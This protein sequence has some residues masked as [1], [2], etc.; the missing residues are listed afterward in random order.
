[1]S[2]SIR[3]DPIIDRL[4]EAFEAGIRS[5]E[6]YSRA[7]PGDK[8]LLDALIPAVDF[9]KTKRSQQAF[10]AQDWKE[11]AAVVERAAQET[12]NL[13]A[14]VGRASYGKLTEATTIDPG[15]HAV[16]VIVQA[17]SDVFAK[18]AAQ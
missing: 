4:S 17:I 18:A 10:T 8:S 3:P 1:M 15:A 16:S 14:K 13:V 9:V 11:F 2:L 7:R 12:K 5:V 6:S